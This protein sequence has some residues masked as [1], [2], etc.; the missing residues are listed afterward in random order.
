MK[1]EDRLVMLQKQNPKIAVL[2]ALRRLRAAL[3]SGQ[4]VAS[5]SQLESWYPALAAEFCD[6]VA[7]AGIE[8]EVLAEIKKNRGLVLEL[9]KAIVQNSEDVLDSAA[10]NFKIDRAL[11]L[12]VF[13]TPLIPAFRA[14]FR[15]SAKNK[16]APLKEGKCPACGRPLG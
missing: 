2:D 6:A 15:E 12:F 3:V 5:L 7:A 13:E 9:G 1:L 8:N 10:K 4:K 14:A 16:S 11:L